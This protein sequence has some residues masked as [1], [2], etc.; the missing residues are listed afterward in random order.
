MVDIGYA[1][2]ST[3][4]QDPELQ[5]RALLATGIAEER[6]YSDKTSGGSRDRP[7]LTAALDY[8]RDGDRLVVWKLDRL[9]RSL[10]HL[11]HLL[12]ELD[13]RGIQFKSLTEG[14]D[15]STPAG[16]MLFHVIA[17]LAEFER[18]LIRER[19]AAGVAA[20][21]ANGRH[22]GRPRLM[23]PAKLR[24]ARTLLDHGE[25]IAA[26]ARAIGVSRATLYRALDEQ[27]H[28]EPSGSSL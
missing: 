14:M 11:V 7:G 17:S 3:V 5:I 10:E 1:R 27:N 21:R 16:R 25:P 18:S 12:G 8:A 9:G 15:T 23:T 19:V 22:G 20:A 28:R 26:A 2:V 6:I 13:A 24:A 4:D